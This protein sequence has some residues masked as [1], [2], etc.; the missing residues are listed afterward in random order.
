MYTRYTRIQIC[1]V[2][3]IHNILISL[4]IP[5]RT[6]YKYV[7]LRVRNYIPLPVQIGDEDALLPSYVMSFLVDSLVSL[8]N[9]P[10]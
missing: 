10:T 5:T 6:L 3:C 2:M 7:L 1:Y 8:V 4:N 9:T